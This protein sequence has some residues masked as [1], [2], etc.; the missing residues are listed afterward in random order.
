VRP[1]CAILYI[2]LEPK[3]LNITRRFRRA[4]N[5][6]LD[7]I[8]ST[9]DATITHK[10]YVNWAKHYVYSKANPPYVKPQLVITYHS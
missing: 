3:L 8:M 9:P 5:P 1:L 6:C 2:T 4:Y 7:D 10:V